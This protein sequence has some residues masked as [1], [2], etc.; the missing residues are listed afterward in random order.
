MISKWCN[1]LLLDCVFDLDYLSWCIYLLCSTFYTIQFFSG[2]L[3][4]KT[5][6]TKSDKLA[7]SKEDKA[8]AS[9][10]NK[11]DAS[12]KR[13]RGRPP[14]V[15]HD[16]IKL[17]DISQLINRTVSPSTTSSPNPS[18][19]DDNS[20]PVP[21]KKTNGVVKSS[22]TPTPL[23]T[24]RPSCR[25]IKPNSRL[26]DFVDPEDKKPL[27]E[28]PKPTGKKRKL[29]AA[30]ATPAAKRGRPRFKNL[31]KKEEHKQSESESSDED[32]ALENHFDES[33]VVRSF[34]P[35]SISPKEWSDSEE[36]SSSEETEDSD[37]KVVNGF[38]PD[39]KRSSASANKQVKPK[40]PVKKAFEPNKDLPKSTS[41]TPSD[42]AAPSRGRR[43]RVASP[44][45]LR[46]TPRAKR[47][48]IQVV[49]PKKGVRVYAP[50][51]GVSAKLTGNVIRSTTSEKVPIATRDTSTLV[52]VNDQGRTGGSAKPDTYS[53]SRLVKELKSIVLP[54]PN[55]RI[56][57]VVSKEQSI[58]EITFTNKQ[59]TERCVKFT[60]VS[61]NYKI[62]FGQKIIVLLGA[63]PAIHAAADVSILLSI[64]DNISEDDP[65]IECI[66][67]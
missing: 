40:L 6:P 50:A 60:K 10:A 3:V 63:P 61:V 17:V 36:K 11:P 16:K 2:V 31:P 37:S 39:T 44:S 14:K 33:L 13:G 8:D 66:N 51:P 56:R 67:N 22:T 41:D 12:I 28:P 34:L 32:E 9:K 4:T 5:T 65:I 23:L 21:K 59:A 47:Q 19:S 53:F 45:P 20:S 27:V 24:R 1:L 30:T 29:S 25:V 57:I 62:M 35:T 43:K 49:T 46:L 15:H 42:K 26:L 48:A 52:L 58:S 18:N 38:K 54:A 64:V 7:A 55:W